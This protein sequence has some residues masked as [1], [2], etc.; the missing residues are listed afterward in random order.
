MSEPENRFPTIRDMRDKLSELV[1][2]GLGDLPVQLIIVPDSTLQAVARASMPEGT[3]YNPNKPA[4]MIEFD[5]VDGRIAVPMMS[6]EKMQ[7]TFSQ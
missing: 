4:L 3:N 7:S 6:V 1:E 2:R 5:G